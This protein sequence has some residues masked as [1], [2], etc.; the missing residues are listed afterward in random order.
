MNV[1]VVYDAS[2][3][4]FSEISRRLTSKNIDPN[5]RIN[6]YYGKQSKHLSVICAKNMLQIFR[7]CINTG[8]FLEDL[9]I[10]LQ[11]TKFCIIFHNFTEYNTIS[12]VLINICKE[13]G[14]PYFVFTEYTDDFFFNGEPMS[15]RF[16]KCV[17]NVPNISKRED[18]SCNIDFEISFATETNSSKDYSQIVHKLRNSYKSIDE[19]RLKKS[20]IFVDNKI[21][22]QYSYLEY[23]A[24]KKKWIKEVIPR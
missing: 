3:D 6:I 23:M 7:K 4:N 17:I 11:F 15:T 16:K 21:P 18:I 12:S 9:R 20:I 8:Q 22:K 5:H 1:L 14:I 24:N 13:N 2:W 19:N 10:Q